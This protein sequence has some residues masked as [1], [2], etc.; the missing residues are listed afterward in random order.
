MKAVG[1]AAAL[2]APVP[3]FLPSSATSI[4]QQYDIDTYASFGTFKFSPSEGRAFA[5]PLQLLPR[6]KAEGLRI[7]TFGEAVWWPSDLRG[8]ID[9]RD[10][11][12]YSIYTSTAVPK[13]VAFRRYIIAVDWGRSTAYFWTE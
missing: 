2:G 3:Q 6:E 9:A 5:A 11:N 1:N 4:V 12:Q 8:R 10:L 7:R 13:A